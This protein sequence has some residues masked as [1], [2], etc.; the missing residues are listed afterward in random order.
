MYTSGTTG[1]PKGNLLNE[2][3]NKVAHLLRKKNVGRGEPV[4]LLFRRSPEMV[5][6]ILAVL[7]AGGAYLPIDPEYPEARIQYM[8]EDSRDPEQPLD[9]ICVVSKKEK[10][11]L[12]HEF[13]GQ[14]QRKQIGLT[15]PQWFEQYAEALPEKPAV[16]AAGRTLTYRE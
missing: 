9:D 11:R 15:I 5:I 7:K 14:V 12:L 8:L 16:S 4:A 1:K 13:N 10:E 3:A 6:A 2:K